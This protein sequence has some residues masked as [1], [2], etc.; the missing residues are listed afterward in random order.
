MFWKR[1]LREYLPN[2][3]N[4][5]KWNEDKP[6]LEEGELV[7]INEKDLPRGVWPMGQVKKVYMGPDGIVRVA[8]VQT[9]HGIYKRPLRK[10]HRL[11][12]RANQEVSTEGEN[13][14]ETC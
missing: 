4:R 13:V 7:I 6:N 11:N 12:I 10:L 1:W 5:S 9:A 3:I 14:T 8:D 2:L